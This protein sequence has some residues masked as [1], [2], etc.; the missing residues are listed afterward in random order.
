M[1]LLMIIIICAFVALATF[2][3]TENQRSLSKKLDKILKHL[4]IKEDK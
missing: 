3:V 4:D 1:D 2:T